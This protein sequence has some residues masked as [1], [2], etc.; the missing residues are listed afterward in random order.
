MWLP[1]KLLGP[2][3][4]PLMRTS[5]ERPSVRARYDA[6]QRDKDSQNHW[7]EAD[8]LSARYANSADVRHILRRRSRYERANNSYLDGIA[9]TLANDT[10]GTGPRLQVRSPDADVNQEITEAFEEWSCCIG[11]AEKL[12]TMRQA[13]CI[14]GEAFAIMITNPKLST[15]VQLDLRLVEADQISTPF[16]APLDQLAVDGIRFDQYGNP[17]EYHVLKYHPGDLFQ[18]YTTQFDRIPAEFVLHW[19]LAKRPQQ[20]R[21]VPDVT[22]A[23]PLFAQLRRF[24][25]AVL[26]AAETAAD[27][28]ALLET[29]APPDSDEDVPEPF[30][31]LQIVKRMMT[32]L[33]AGA[34]LAQLKAEQPATSFEMFQRQILIEIARCL[35]MPYNIAAGNSA[36]YNYSS[37]RL[38][39]QTYYKS[40]AVDQY[41]VEECMLKRIFLAWLAE[42]VLLGQIERQP[43]PLKYQWFWDGHGHVDPEKEAT[44]QQIRLASNTS[45]LADEW[46]RQGHDWRERLTQ[47]AEE[48][49]LM[50]ELGITPEQLAPTPKPSPSRQ[51][52]RNGTS[53]EDN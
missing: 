38:D 8:D 20:Y 53:Y 27:F 15:P 21:G 12:R 18:G 5:T 34:K 35:G 11:L 26:A 3:G 19:F 49:N 7:A 40:I 17:L 13:R 41:H 47:R 2:N 25:L 6:A 30:E 37:G 33:P 50:K 4:Q 22:A 9:I 43:K 52:S 24:T 51:P 32:T 46:A 45:T 44:A 23:L 36:G 31:S 48:I 39:H 16:P 28:A 14:D 1:L 10:I 29:Q 42:A